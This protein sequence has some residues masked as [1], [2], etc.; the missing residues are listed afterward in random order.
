ME[1]RTIKEYFIDLL[2]TKNSAVSKDDILNLALECGIN[3]KPKLA[4][5]KIIDML[6][7]HGY[8]DKLFEY[9]H[10]FIMIPSWEVADY[11]SISTNKINQLKAIGAIKEEP[12]SKEFY[13]RKN[14][15]YFNADTY[16]LSVLNYDKE[17][18]IEAYNNAYG[19]NT[20]ELRIE[21]KTKDEVSKLINIL[22]K[23]FKIE[24]T[25]V[26]YTHRNGDGYYSYFKVKLLNNSKEEE[27]ALLA[28]ISRLKAEK[29]EI[30]KECQERIDRILDPLKEYLGEDLNI[31]NLEFKLD[32][33]VNNEVNKLNTIP[34]KNSRNAGRKPKFDKI[35]ITE[36]EIMKENGYS[37]NKIA[38]EYHTTKA[39]VIKYLKHKGK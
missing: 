28:E 11:Y 35:K 19:G 26:T 13:S 31:F 25:P 36:M 21:T 18:L 20:H 14:R 29:E 32:K 2:N 34:I 23:I 1:K 24:K 3:I 15:E 8:Y 7:E 27:N 4:K 9:F 16:P 10:E 33:L 6:I 17:K 38:K 39:T 30:K 5:S 12:I 37:Y 22:K